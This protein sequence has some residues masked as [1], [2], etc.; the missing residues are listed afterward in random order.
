M[1][2]RVK[3]RSWREF[4]DGINEETTPKEMW[5]KIGL[6]TNKYTSKDVTE[7]RW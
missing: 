3:R 4:V 5:R 6:L 7:G 2:Q 1:F